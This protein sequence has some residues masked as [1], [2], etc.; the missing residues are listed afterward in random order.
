MRSLGFFAS[1]KGV[2][3]VRHVLETDDEKDGPHASTHFALA[4]ISPTHIPQKAVQ[5]ANP[6]MILAHRMLIGT[7]QLASRH[8]TMEKYDF[9]SD[10]GSREGRGTT[11]SHRNKIERDGLL[12][13][14]IGYLAVDLGREFANMRAKHHARNAARR[15]FIHILCRAPIQRHKLAKSNHHTPRGEGG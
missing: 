3:N 14:I 1:S 13:S 4:H 7:V 10:C 5:V 6:Q 11:A 9:N 8:H 15:P 2:Q 12:N